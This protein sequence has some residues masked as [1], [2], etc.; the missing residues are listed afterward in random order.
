MGG[1][2]DFPGGPSDSLCKCAAWECWVKTKPQSCLSKKGTSEM[3]WMFNLALQQSY[4]CI[5]AGEQ[6]W[7]TQMILVLD[8]LFISALLLSLGCLTPTTCC[9]A[10]GGFQP[11][12]AASPLLQP[13][14]AVPCATNP[15]ADRQVP[16]LTL[17]RCCQH[18]ALLQT[19]HHAGESSSIHPSPSLSQ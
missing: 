11:V 3:L 2:K 4:G 12:D 8:Q 5:Q 6:L 1:V 18:L 7:S 15:I 19:W 17:P 13:C 9:L 10:S 14:Q 16:A